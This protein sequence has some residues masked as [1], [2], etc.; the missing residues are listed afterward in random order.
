MTQSKLPSLNRTK[1]KKR[2]L[3]VRAVHVVVHQRKLR[4]QLSRNSHFY[5]GIKKSSHFDDWIFFIT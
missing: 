3:C 1:Q 5:S 4:R 2:K